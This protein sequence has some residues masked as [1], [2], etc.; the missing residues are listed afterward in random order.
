MRAAYRLSQ[1]LR[2]INIDSKMLV[3]NKKS[4]DQQVI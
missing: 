1:E 3:Q 2:K 4:D